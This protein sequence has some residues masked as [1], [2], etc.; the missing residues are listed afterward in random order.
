LRRQNKRAFL[1]LSLL[2]CLLWQ[3]I[4]ARAAQAV[5]AAAFVPEVGGQGGDQVIGALLRQG[6]GAELPALL[7]KIFGAEAGAAADVFD[8]DAERLL[9]TVTEGAGR[10][11]EESLDEQ[12]EKRTDPENHQRHRHRPRRRRQHHGLHLGADAP[13]AGSRRDGVTHTA[14]RAGAPARAEKKVGRPFE[15][16]YLFRLTEMSRTGIEPVTR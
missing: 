11:A 15:S 2:S 9:R 4:P 8:E 5:G 3:S 14:A 1:S 6:R 16:P 10:R 12:I 7:E 13:G